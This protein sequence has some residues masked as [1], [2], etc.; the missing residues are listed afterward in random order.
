M[1]MFL[2]QRCDE[3]RDSDDGC[4]EGEAG[5]GSG[6][7]CIDCMADMEDEPEPK[8]DMSYEGIVRGLLALG[9]P[10]DIAREL[11]REKSR[12]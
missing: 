2:C 4:V 12:D 10:E 3:M 11:A 7:I 5:K 8:R 1:S 6:L 9:C